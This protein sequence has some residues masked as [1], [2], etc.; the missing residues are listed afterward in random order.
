MSPDK[1]DELPPDYLTGNKHLDI[2]FNWSG[3]E[4]EIET[5]IFKLFEIKVSNNLWEFNLTFNF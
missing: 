1:F 3:S 5:N 2:S 4:I